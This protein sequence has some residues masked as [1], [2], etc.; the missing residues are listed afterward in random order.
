MS[1]ASHCAR[2]RFINCRMIAL[3]FTQPEMGGKSTG[4]ICTENHQPNAK[5]HVDLEDCVLAGYSLFTT[6]KA[7][8]AVSC[9][10]RGK[11]QAYLQFKQNLPDGFQRLGSW[12]VELF[13]RIA[14]PPSTGRNE[15][16]ENKRP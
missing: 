7:G 10:I 2:G 13:S 8:E 6:G 11:V 1:Y 9:A 14:P 16:S 5:L 3:N 4:I 15:R 12:P